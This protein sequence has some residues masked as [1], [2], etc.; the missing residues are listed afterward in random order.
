M[1]LRPSPS[2]RL[3]L[4]AAVN[5]TNR[6]VAPTEDKPPTSPGGTH[7]GSQPY[8]HPAVWRNSS[9]PPKQAPHGPWNKYKCKDEGGPTVLEKVVRAESP[10]HQTFL[11][12]SPSYRRKCTQCYR[13]PQSKLTTWSWNFSHCQSK[14][15]TISSFRGSGESCTMVLF[16]I[17]KAFLTSQPGGTDLRAT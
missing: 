6:I 5:L 17:S 12:S 14:V 13:S 16:E 11:M 3:N 9:T 2:I 10:A 8:I 1:P 4:K 7:W 15:K